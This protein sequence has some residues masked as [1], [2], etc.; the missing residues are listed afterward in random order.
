[1]TSSDKGT[2]QVDIT[3]LTTLGDDEGIS[4]DSISIPMGNLIPGAEISR[5]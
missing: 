2:R 3:N 5:Q 4:T 1:M